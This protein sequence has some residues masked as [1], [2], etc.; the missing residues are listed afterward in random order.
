[1]HEHSEAFHANKGYRLAIHT[2]LIIFKIE[3]CSMLFKRYLYGNKTLHAPPFYKKMSHFNIVF[4]M[5]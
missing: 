4:H 2:T 3:I 5:T 1:M